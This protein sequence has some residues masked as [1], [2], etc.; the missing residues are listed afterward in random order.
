M[1]L[2]TGSAQEQL[3]F[4]P[5]KHASEFLRAFQLV[6]VVKEVLNT[7]ILDPDSGELTEASIE[8]LRKYE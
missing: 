6:T 5:D 2:Q 7:P 3:D 8:I 4:D 1:D